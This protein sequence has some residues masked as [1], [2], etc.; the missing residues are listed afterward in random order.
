[1]FQFLWPSAKHL[2]DLNFSGPG[3]ATADR[4]RE[5]EREWQS[6]R[7]AREVTTD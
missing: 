6:A 5:R 7:G 2:Q 3:R 1:M 4:E